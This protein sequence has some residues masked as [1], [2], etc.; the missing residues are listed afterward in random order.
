MLLLVLGWALASA[1]L[2]PAQEAQA[3]QIGRTI[4]C[5]VCQGLPITESTSDLSHQMMR[6]LRSQVQQG[7]GADQIIQYF[8]AR[9]GDTVLL[10]PPRR[11]INLLLWLAPLL[12]LLLGGLWLL[13]YLRRPAGA[14][15]PLPS[16]PGPDPDDEDPYL[17]QVRAVSSARK[18]RDA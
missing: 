8:A 13:S 18:A 10:N 11:G 1:P 7:R 3:Q 14:A 2:S 9:Y 6:E 16:T 5:P 4:R 15:A 12:A 17:R